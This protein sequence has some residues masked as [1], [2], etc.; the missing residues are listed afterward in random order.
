M[1]QAS[2]LYSLYEVDNEKW[3]VQT[4]KLLKEKQ[5]EN[6]DLEHLIEELE[7]VSRRDRLTVESFL[8]QIIRH[9]LLL[10]YWQEQHEYN[11]NHWQAEIMSFRN[12]LNE[13]LT[14]NLR[15]H[16]QENQLKVYQKA[17][18]YVKQKTGMII[19]FPEDCPYTL[20][21]LL[22]QDWLP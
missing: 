9:L 4:L 7:A 20:E 14:Q 15:N 6:L 18:K 10:E 12:Q 1:T 5:L 21:Q 3:L 17:L 8:E 13:Y 19:H 16:L 11:A 22:N 2:E